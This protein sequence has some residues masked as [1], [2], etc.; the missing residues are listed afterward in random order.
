MRSWQESLPTSSYSHYFARQC[1]VTPVDLRQG[2]MLSDQPNCVDGE[3]TT[4]VHFQDFSELSHTVDDAKLDLDFVERVLS[5][6]GPVMA[7]VWD[8]ANW[9]WTEWPLHLKKNAKTEQD[10][11]PW[12]EW[13]LFSHAAHAVA[14]VRD[15]LFRQAVKEV[16]PTLRGQSTTQ[17]IYPSTPRGVTDIIHSVAEYEDP[18]EDGDA[19]V[20][21]AHQVSP[22]GRRCECSRASRLFGQSRRGLAV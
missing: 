18:S 12:L 6:T 8:V 14:A 11:Y 10:Y 2:V 16:P 1:P 22:D 20:H 5:S 4:R 7:Y 3:V 15:R 13:V 21:T 9:Q 19:S 17:S